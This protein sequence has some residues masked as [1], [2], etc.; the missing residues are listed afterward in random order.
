M[1]L[2]HPYIFLQREPRKYY[3]YAWGCH[4]KI[5]FTFWR[6]M[7]SKTF[8][9]INLIHEH[10]A[11]DELGGLHPET[12]PGHSQPEEEHFLLYHSAG[13]RAIHGYIHNFPVMISQGWGRLVFDQGTD[14]VTLFSPCSQQGMS[15]KS[16]DNTKRICY[17]Q[18]EFLNG[19][20]NTVRKST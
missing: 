12:H 15:I 18:G 14:R 1:I 16:T 20:Y 2:A 8:V 17:S 3:A 4:I 9:L 5:I 13:A 6:T 7:Q 19:N 10:K 11:K